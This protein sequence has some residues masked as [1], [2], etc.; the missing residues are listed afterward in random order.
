MADTLN[1]EINSE[2]HITGRQNR[3]PVT[4]GGVHVNTNWE[5]KVLQQAMGVGTNLMRKA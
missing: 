3:K 1:Y 5:L 2:A 4:L